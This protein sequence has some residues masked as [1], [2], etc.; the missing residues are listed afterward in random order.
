[1]NIKNE[2]GWSDH[3]IVVR[4]GRF[5]TVVSKIWFISWSLDVKNWEIFQ[6]DFFGS[7]LFHEN[8]WSVTAGSE[9]IIQRSL[10]HL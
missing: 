6:G 7:F 1:M 5:L 8:S 10:Q 2:F 4:I 3:Q 9:E